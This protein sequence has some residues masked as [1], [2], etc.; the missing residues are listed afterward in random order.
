MKIVELYYRGV[1]QEVFDDSWMFDCI[2]KYLKDN[3]D[4][5]HNVKKYEAHDRGKISN[6][7]SITFFNVM[8]LNKI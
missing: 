3:Y 5:T 2:E 6:F 1:A 8:E 7:M 4:L